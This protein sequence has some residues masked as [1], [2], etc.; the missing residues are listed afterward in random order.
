MTTAS[1]RS[2]E[3][4]SCTHPGETA[5]W[6]AS[7]LRA[8]SYYVQPTVVHKTQCAPGADC[9]AYIY[10]DGAFSFTPTDDAGKPLPQPKPAAA[11][12]K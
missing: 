8:G 5:E 10:E 7:N 2:R 12:K 3:L 11:A 1:N 9:V 4:E 6:P